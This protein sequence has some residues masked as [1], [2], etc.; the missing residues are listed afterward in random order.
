MSLVPNGAAGRGG[1]GHA[2]TQPKQRSVG[3]ADRPPTTELHVLL[4]TARGHRL[5]TC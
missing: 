4:L 5:R 1:G 2:V 3:S